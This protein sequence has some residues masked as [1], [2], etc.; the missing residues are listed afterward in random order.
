ML[1]AFARWGMKQ[2]IKRV[3]F[4]GHI[5]GSFCVDQKE[6]HDELFFEF[7]SST[8]PKKKTK[9]DNERKVIQL[10][11]VLIKILQRDSRIHEC[12]AA[13]FC[14][15]SSYSVR[16]DSQ[17]TARDREPSTEQRTMSVG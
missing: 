15:S 4:A 17:K 8:G 12:V 13:S 6:K 14:N 5:R 9:R 1:T 16:R 11:L 2:Y 3:N 7:L 10:V